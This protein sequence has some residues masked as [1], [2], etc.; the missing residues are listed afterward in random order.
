M[1]KCRYACI[2]TSTTLNHLPLPILAQPAKIPRYP[3]YGVTISCKSIVQI[4]MTMVDTCPRQYRLS[5]TWAPL[6]QSLG[7]DAVEVARQCRLPADVFH[8]ANSTVS[9]GQFFHMWRALERI[10][11]S[12]VMPLHYGRAVLS[13]VVNLTLIAIMA[14]PDMLHAVQ[15][16]T[17]FRSLIGPTH[18]DVCTEGDSVTIALVNLV[19]GESPP[20]SMVMAELVFLL[21]LCREATGEAI[22]PQ[23]LELSFDWHFSSPYQ[24]FF[25]LRPERGDQDLITIARS[26]AQRPFLSADQSLWNYFE[27]VLDKRLQQI[28][29]DTRYV[30]QVKARLIEMLPRGQGSIDDVAHS[31]SVSTR[32]L[33][34]RLREEGSSY[35]QVLDE[36]RADLALYY[37]RNSDLAGYEISF[38]LGFED[39]NSF[40]R[41]FR[42]WT[43]MT[44]E[45]VKASLTHR[46]SA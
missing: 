23:R 11:D 33:Q 34:R 40:F 1:A 31:I 46:G 28:D 37:L 17:R 12:E 43:G 26:D 18:F 44:P 24:D 6:L 45:S 32:T 21:A 35:R 13:R 5:L 16:L 2:P 20:P 19:D 36:T 29:Q 25:G 4:K 38:L 42:K 39:Q 27:T 15:N 8:R 30:G 7:V 3:G 14:S 22:V 9:G 41:A 10:A